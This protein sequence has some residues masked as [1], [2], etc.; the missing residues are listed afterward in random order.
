[1]SR[2]DGAWI[3][4][5]RLKMIAKEVAKTFPE[6]AD[7]EHVLLWIEVNIGLSRKK[8]QEYLAKVVAVK[9]WRIE[10]GRILPPEV[11]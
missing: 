8:A 11:K 4:A 3:K 7:L 6:G 5:Q 9:G 1:M 2:R 10:D